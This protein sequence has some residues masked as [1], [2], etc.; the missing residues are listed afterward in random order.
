MKE[1]RN[2]HESD[3]E[4][5]KSSAKNKRLDGK[6]KKTSKNHAT[7]LTIIRW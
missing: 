4:S 3:E 5:E 7:M 6:K 1:M 2:G